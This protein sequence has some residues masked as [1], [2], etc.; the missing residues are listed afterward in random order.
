MKEWQ[1]WEAMAN[2]FGKVGDH[3]RKAECLDMALEILPPG[4]EEDRDR[5]RT[6]MDDARTRALE[7]GPRP[8]SSMEGFNEE[9]LEAR[10]ALG[11][12]DAREAMLTAIRERC[13]SIDGV[14]EAEVFLEVVDTSSLEEDL[15]R[16]ALEDLIDEGKVYRVRPGRLMVDGVMS[17]PDV[18]LAVLG[19]L[20]ELSTG[21]RGGSREEVVRELV[22]RG[23]ARD[24]LESVIDDLEESGRL[25]EAH[26]GQLRAALEVKAIQEIHHMVIASVEEMD[27]DGK[28]VLAARLERA[29]TSRGFELDEVLEAIEELVDEGDLL[30]EG[31]EI[32]ISGPKLDDDRA[33]ELLLEVIH[34]LTEDRNAPVPLMKVLR[35]ARSRGMGAVLLH[36]TMDDLVDAGQVWKDDHGLHLTGSVPKD[37]GRGRETMLEAVRQLGHGRIGASRVEVLDL[38]MDGGLGEEEA[39]ELL[40]YLIDDGLVHE[41]GEGFLKPG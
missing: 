16:G 4:L 21:G 11:L 26:R 17:D 7:E 9:L 37:T 33:R 14:P 23:F 36:R 3:H 39:R 13:R 28:G 20:G 34:A 30:R 35:A 8:S 29:L 22:Q 38:A 27:P 32:R 19:V 6:G 15:V 41:A 31:N 5:L 10:E 24:T 18:E 2:D 12:E 1:R 40:E 25:N